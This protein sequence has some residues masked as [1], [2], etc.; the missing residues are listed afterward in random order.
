MPLLPFGPRRRLAAQLLDLVATPVAAYRVTGKGPKVRLKPLSANAPAANV[1]AP[2]AAVAAAAAEACAAGEPRAAGEVGGRSV[3]AVP[4]GDDR[5]A[6]VYAE[7]PAAAASDETQAVLDAMADV[8]LVYPLA[9]DGPGP[10]LAFNQAAVD[11]Y[12]YAPATL[13]TLRV[14]DLIDPTRFDVSRGIDELMRRREGRFD[15]VHVTRDGRRIPMQTAARLFRYG[16]QLC[17]LAVCRDDSDRRAFQREITR[18]NGALER[19][20]AERTAQLEAFATNLKILHRLTTVEHPTTLDRARAYLDAG[21]EMFGL[22]HGI[23]SA[24][25]T[26]PLTGI[27]MYRVDAVRSPGDEIAVG[28][29]LPLADTFCDSVLDARATVSFADAAV[30]AHISC[31]AAHTE[32]GLRAFIGTPIWIGGEIV[33][34]LNFSS[35]EPRPAP[36][37]PTDHDL[38]EIMAGAVAMRLAQDAGAPA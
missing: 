16:G 33:G 9:P 5:V 36:F 31:I 12:G 13:R 37:A 21:C 32:R 14:A 27:P 1:P 3:R 38:I 20:V 24:V 22:T 26:D 19:R 4:L 25:Y 8:V 29:V 6:L 2:D 7:A 10:L 28:T 17:V 30:D 11:T 15:V 23:L 35:P 18:A 34:T